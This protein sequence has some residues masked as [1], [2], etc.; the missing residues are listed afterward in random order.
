MILERV[1]MV[2]YD[3]TLISNTNADVEPLHLYVG[4]HYVNYKLIYTPKDFCN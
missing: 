2:H 3:Q 1:N 4:V